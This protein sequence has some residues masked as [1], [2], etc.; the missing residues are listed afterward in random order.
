LLH[1]AGIRRAGEIELEEIGKLR[2]ELPRVKNQFLTE[3]AGLTSPA[4]GVRRGA[5][6]LPYTGIACFCDITHT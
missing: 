1:G 3:Y 5:E 6:T 4:L 2:M